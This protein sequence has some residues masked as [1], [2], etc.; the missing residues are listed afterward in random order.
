MMTVN[1]EPISII[2][3]YIGTIVA[4]LFSIIFW[5]NPTILLVVWITYFIYQ[6]RFWVMAWFLLGSPCPSYP[7]FPKLKIIEARVRLAKLNYQADKFLIK[8]RVIIKSFI[9]H[10]YTKLIIMINLLKV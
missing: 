7:V 10:F 3:M 8:K 6:E 5:N 4:I 2:F 9:M 1:L